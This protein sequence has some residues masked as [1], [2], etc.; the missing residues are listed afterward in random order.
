MG[1][2]FE[3]ALEP[4][5]GR[6]GVPLVVGFDMVSRLGAGASGEVWLAE[7]L[8]SGRMVALKI[9]RSHG[10]LGEAPE[11]LRREV[12]MLAKLA[13]PN[14]VILHRTIVTADGRPGLAMEW[15]D[16]WPL[17]EW[18]QMHPNLSLDEKLRLFGGIVRGV[19]F[20]HDHGVIHRDLKPANVIVDSQGEVKIVDFGLARLHQETQSVMPDGGSIG[21]SGTLHFMAPEQA[22][23]G[24]GSRA[25]PVDVYALG[26][27]FYRILTGTWLRPVQATAS[28]TLALVL[29]PPPLEL[30]GGGRLLPADVRWILRQALAP[31]PAGR[32]CHAR[33]LQADLERLAAK[34]PVSAR[35]HTLIYLVTT[36]L[37]RQSR[38]SAVAAVL[39]LIGLIAGGAI[40]AKNRR[41]AARNEANLRAAYSLTTK[42]LQQL[43]NE[44]RMFDGQG[45]P[46]LPMALFEL[47]HAD[48]DPELP[49]D[50]AGELD[51][52][53]YQALLA[54]LRSANSESHGSYGPALA[55]I[56][57]ALDSYSDLAMEAP[58]DPG[59]LRDAALARHGFARLLS[60]TGQWAAA[61]RQT[62]KVHLQIDRLSAW[63]GFD[64][65]SLA[66]VRCD[67]MRILAENEARN[68]RPENAVFASEKALDACAALPGGLLVRQE[69]EA[70]PRLAVAAA[71]LADHAISAGADSIVRVT[72]EIDRAISTSRAALEKEPGKHPLKLGL[73]VCLHARARLMAGEP[74]ADPIPL[75]GEATGLTIFLPQETNPDALPQVW[76]LSNTLTQWADINLELRDPAL[77]R[78]AVRLAHGLTTHLR[79]EGDNRDEVLIERGHIYLLECR[80]AR[81][82]GNRDY[83]A[84]TVAMA[85]TL[86]RSRQIRYP[87]RPEL[88]FM[89]VQALSEGLA[90]SD[91][92]E[93][94]WTAKH[95]KH[96]ADLLPKV[97]A[98][99]DKLTPRQQTCLSL[100]K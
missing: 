92:P 81:R 21:V 8:E 31:D 94:G 82:S 72:P 62:L 54:D 41:V 83:A 50:A 27:L 25:M 67:G 19:A 3:M 12:E 40:F 78:E 59:R 43:R 6:Q 73:A 74:G 37:R 98:W 64:A 11:Y 86:L 36:F 77:V 76:S 48:G 88:A 32:Y 44:L 91:L 100:L 13:H 18:L 89:T 47:N 75:L 63:P 9:L 24:K 99:K 2:L 66:P 20:L 58:G 35:K 5:D 93:T 71:A 45:R 30:P 68:G 46:E 15:I 14:L 39:V 61:A 29:D 7:E 95:E 1:A 42:T 65:T 23:N 38:R 33:D 28:E 90:L 16:G 34:Q 85:L 26:L 79:T 96:Y 80:L 56:Q 84:T 10:Q 53:Y 4:A 51:L 55:S 69:N 70:M 49:V 87:E 97:R 60:R 22:A 57:Q 17:D 52:R